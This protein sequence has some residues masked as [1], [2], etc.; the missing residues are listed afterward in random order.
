MQID[1]ITGAMINVTGLKQSTADQLGMVLHDNTYYL[2][3][4]SS[5]NVEIGDSKITFRMI[6][7][8]KLGNVTI[9]AKQEGGALVDYTGAGIYPI[10][11]WYDGILSLSDVL[12]EVETGATTARVTGF[13]L[14]FI[15][16]GLAAFL[17]WRK[18][19]FG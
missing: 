13:A 17:T 16:A 9:L 7:P 12:E 15:F 1:K 5:K 2:Y 19:K 18:I 10:N 4:T 6:D 8:A 11:L 3:N 14:A